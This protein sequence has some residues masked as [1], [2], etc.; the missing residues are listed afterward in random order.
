MSSKIIPNKLENL[1]YYIL[2][3][4]N[5]ELMCEVCN[6]NWS[7]DG[8]AFMR[9]QGGAKNGMYYRQFRC[10]GKSRGRC[11]ASY[12]H[13][14]FL[15]LARR[16]LGQ[17]FIDRIQNALEVT[18]AAK[19]P[20]SSEIFP[21]RKR[22]VYN[23]PKDCPSSL[24]QSSPC[25]QGHGE[26]QSVLFNS[27]IQLPSIFPAS[28]GKSPLNDPASSFPASRGKSPLNDPASSF[29]D[30]RGKS[31]LSDPPSLFPNSRGKSPL[32][33]P[34]SSFPNSWGNAIPKSLESQLAEMKILFLEQKL[35]LREEQISFLNEKIGVLKA[36]Q[37]PE[38]SSDHPV[39][40]SFP[41]PKLQ[42]YSRVVQAPNSFASPVEPSSHSKSASTPP[43]KAKIPDSRGK[44]CSKYGVTIVYFLG[45][46]KMK[47]GQF[48]AD[49][50]KVGLS[51]TNVKNIS[52]I[53]NNIA[54]LLVDSAFSQAFIDSAKGLGFEIKD[55]NIVE[56][57]KKN[58]I[59]INY[60]SPNSSL[61][62][63]IKSNF[64][65]RVSHEIKS[66]S[67]ENVR[68]FYLE[69]AESLGW[70]DSLLVPSTLLGFT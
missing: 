24:P 62:E 1:T 51:L 28:R 59:W 67:D 12:T 46:Q 35:I 52:L 64:I 19:R 40:S 70:K 38:P 17:E 41:S 34:P 60:G 23:R 63:V 69:W 68:R 26:E 4:Y 43:A 36:Q 5:T 55:L 48:R 66:V 45:L 21:P 25:P 8:T 61:N 9:D 10:K 53:G 50:K 57:S 56:R 49:L 47:I 27:R 54:E 44:L 39:S 29:P 37:L 31:P 15:A 18:P 13:G 33:D 14:D 6:K 22:V 16:Q 11:S 42:S 30:S 2:D 3:N 7:P 32:S 65:R 20:L 58:P